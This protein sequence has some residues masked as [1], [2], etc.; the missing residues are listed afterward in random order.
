[1]RE[2]KVVWDRKSVEHISRHGIKVSEVKAVLLDRKK[3]MRRVKKG[4][5][6]VIGKS[7][8]KILFIIVRKLKSGKYKVVTAREATRKEKRIYKK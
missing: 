3:F 7:R 1:L 2:I 4:R 8:D 6:N 5:Y